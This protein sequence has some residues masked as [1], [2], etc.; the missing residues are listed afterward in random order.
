MTHAATESTRSFS[1]PTCDID[2][3][4]RAQAAVMAAVE[5]VG[6]P[7]RK[8]SSEVAAVMLG[9]V[10]LVR[11]HGT[12][13]AEARA[14]PLAI[15]GL[16]AD[17]FHPLTDERTARQLESEADRHEYAI[18]DACGI[19]GEA[20]ALW[21]EHARAL[22]A[23]AAASLMLARVLDEKSRKARQSQSIA[24]QRLGV[25]AS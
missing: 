4:S 2:V 25:R 8:L 16:V 6:C 23:D 5:R 9:I 7:H 1:D 10:A 21:D 18:Q 24:R 20:P 14:I 13:E 11:K 17:L 3:Y 15:D 22:R 19:E 12:N